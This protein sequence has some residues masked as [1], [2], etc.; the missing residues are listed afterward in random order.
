[1]I[2][3]LLSALAAAQ[4]TATLL[5]DLR[6][7]PQ[8]S[9]ILGFAEMQGRLFF[10]A[11]TPLG[12]DLFATDGTPA[13][14]GA[15][16]LPARSV[17]IYNGVPVAVGPNLFF[18][19]RT[20]AEGQE[21]W[22]SDG[23]VAGTQRVTDLNPGPTDA[24]AD[25]LTSW[26]GSCFFTAIVPLGATY[27]LWRSDGT[28]AGTARL[29]QWLAPLRLLTV[30]GG[31]LFFVATDTSSGDELWVLDDPQA[32]P[33]MVLD[34]WPGPQGSNIGEMI[35]WRDKLWF[36]ANDGVHGLELWSSDGTA[37]NTALVAD[38]VPGS[39]SAR[40]AI[41]T[42]TRDYLFFMT[43]DISTY[44]YIWQTDG[45]AA[46]TQLVPH[47]PALVGSAG[48]TAITA[49]GNVVYAR[50]ALQVA[51]PTVDLWRMDGTP[52]GTMRVRGADQNRALSPIHLAAAG[53]RFV[54]FQGNDGVAGNELWRSDGT[55]TGTTLVADLVPGSGSSGAYLLRPIGGRLVFLAGTAAT[56]TEPFAVPLD[57]YGQAVGSAC[58]APGRATSLTATDPVLGQTCTLTGRA[59]FPGSTGFLYLGLPAAAPLRLPVAGPSCRWLLS[60]ALFAALGTVVPNGTTWSLG[61]PIPN[62]Q[63][64]AR[65]LLRVQGV[66]AL[67]DAPGGLDVTN[68]ADLNLGR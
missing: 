59:A 33:R 5:G 8:G 54:Y 39:G 32:A 40:P 30:A 66:F 26:R 41:F 22:K 3:L 37:A 2:P 19:A 61:L 67:T 21:L 53:S 6:P 16:G 10:T 24:F 38:V 49:V 60:P 1:V 34:V 20:A 52:S 31:K 55:T 13:G 58:G 44:S 9:N 47:T 64:F 23:T 27:S 11:Q 45:T 35:E 57:G 14:T 51:S 25:L 4:T 48:P 36:Y 28:A 46:G 17:Q 7:G 63:V 15:F 56:G 62:V 29:G 68:A 18:L 42:P 12:F 65:R 50:A 43:A